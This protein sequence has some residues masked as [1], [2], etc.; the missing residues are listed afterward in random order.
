MTDLSRGT[1][2]VRSSHSQYLQSSDFA[3]STQLFYLWRLAHELVTPVSR[4]CLRAVICESGGARS[5]YAHAD[6]LGSFFHSRGIGR[7]IFC[8]DRAFQRVFFLATSDNR[9]RKKKDLQK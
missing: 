4:T 2:A 8:S 3:F 7:A 1:R 9:Q 6:M 5:W